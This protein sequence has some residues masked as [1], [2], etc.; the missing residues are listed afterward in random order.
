MNKRLFLL[1]F[2]LLPCV[3]MAQGLSGFIY[4]GFFSAQTSRFQPAQ[5]GTGYERFGLTLGHL[6]GSLSNSAISRGWATAVAGGDV[7]GVP[8]WIQTLPQQ[9]AL[10]LQAQAELLSGYFRLGASPQTGLTLGWSITDRALMKATFPGDL[11]RLA[12]FGNAPYEDQTVRMPLSMRAM[13]LRE[14]GISAAAPFALGESGATLR[15]GGRIR[16]VQG[17]HA[18]RVYPASASLYTAP[19]GQYLSLDYQFTALATFDPESESPFLA[20]DA[21]RPRG[22]GFATDLGVRLSWKNIFHADL[23]LLDMG[24]VRFQP[25]ARNVSYQK[26]DNIRFEGAV[27]ENP[28]EDPTPVI[29]STLFQNILDGSRT[30]GVGITMPMPARVRIGGSATLMK[31]D[32]KSR[33]YAAHTFSAAVTRELNLGWGYNTYLETGY[34]FNFKNVLEATVVYGGGA[35]HWY[36]GA[37]A[38]LRTGPMRFGLGS[39]DLSAALSPGGKGAAFNGVMSVGF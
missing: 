19:E 33:S 10:H 34:T 7:S 36:G 21:A 18:A 24:S 14:Y 2:G 35:G 4:G 25:D 3:G 37:F 6:Q 8:A 16:Y 17:I 23:A 20:S 11:V 22:N 5:L 1:L 26:A 27:I 32:K 13:W 38:G 29:D 31:T 9:P 15:V 30:T 39:Y 12:W 28:F